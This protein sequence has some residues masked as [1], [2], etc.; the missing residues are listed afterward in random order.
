MRVDEVLTL[1]QYDI[2]AHRNCPKKQPD[3]NH[4]DFRRRRGDAIYD[5]SF[6]EPMQRASVHG[7]ANMARDL[8]GL[9]ALISRQFWYFGRKALEIPDRFY[10]IIH[11]T[12]GEKYKSNGQLLPAFIN[13]LGGL[14]YVPNKVHGNPT[15]WEENDST[16]CR[17]L[18]TCRK[19]YTAL[20]EASPGRA[21]RANRG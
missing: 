16:D 10:P 8:S 6:R 13:W 7:P 9:H 18:A 11:Q 12:Q 5:F 14:G 1:A 15:M 2:W 20:A 17:L 19:H 3:W 21:P 4:R